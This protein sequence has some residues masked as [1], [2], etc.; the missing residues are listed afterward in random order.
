MLLDPR[1]LAVTA[2]FASA[3]QALAILYIWSTQLRERA[4]IELA[5]AAALVPM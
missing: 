1:T 3:I 2:S 4:V 5:T